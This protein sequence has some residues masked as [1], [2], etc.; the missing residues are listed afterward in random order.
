MKGERGGARGCG[1][2]TQSNDHFHSPIRG[3]LWAPCSISQK[4][5]VKRL[6][7]TDD[8]SIC[9]TPISASLSP[10]AEVEKLQ[11]LIYLKGCAGD[12]VG[13]GCSAHRDHNAQLGMSI[14]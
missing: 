11:Q 12:L 3:C 10:L 9:P 6:T 4:R 7:G 14:E 2:I 5:R 8:I 1:V 13:S